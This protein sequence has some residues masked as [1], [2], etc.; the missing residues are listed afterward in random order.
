MGLRVIAGAARGRRLAAPSGRATRPTSGLVRGALFNMLVHRG[1]LR[2]A[3]VLDLFAGSGALGIEALSRGAAR[4][5]F[6]E[7]SPVAERVLRRNLDT[8][9]FDDRA[10]V[11]ATGVPQALRRLAADGVVVDGVLMD[12]PFD[13]G[14]VGRVLPLLAASPLLRREGWIALEHT[15]SEPVPAVPG[16]HVVAE[17]RHGRA[18]IVLLLREDAS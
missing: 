4:S 12:P 13:R 14:W 17:R 16:L 10:I 15:T 18:H 11:L 7:H 1:W 2:D 8:S 6:V 9:G 3:V 5:Y